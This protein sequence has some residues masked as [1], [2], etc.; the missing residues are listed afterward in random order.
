MTGFG[1]GRHAAGNVEV[2]TEVR[3]VNHRFL[4]ISLRVPRT[5]F[6]FEPEVRRIISETI[7]RGKID[8]TVTRTGSKGAV[9]D[10][11]VDHNLAASYRNCLEELKGKFGL[12]GEITLS[13]MLTMKEIVIPLENEE[14]IEREWPLVK[15]SLKAALGALNQMRRTEGA[16][17]WRDIEKR[18]HLIEETAELIGP[19]TVRVAAA[20][21]ERL[22]RRVQELT[23]GLDL[24]EDRLIQEVALIAERSDV[25]EELVRLKS[26]VEQFLSFGR[27]GSPIGRRLDFLLQEL[28][29]EVNT[30][31][32]K[33]VSTEIA[34]HVVTL[35]TEVERIREQTQNLE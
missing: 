20:A 12:A 29:R 14:S 11:I 2:L 3:T 35:K 34:A 16:A 21:K 27:Q 26:H 1:R 24:D 17:L 30:V 5:Y 7:Q 6:S 19:L 33:S 25:T 9:M 8:V 28:H 31:G 13:D 10:V 23:G 4:D 15:A 18:L 32:S 22:E